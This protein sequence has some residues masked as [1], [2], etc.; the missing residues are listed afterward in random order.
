MTSQAIECWSAK[1][2]AAR[3]E[4]PFGQPRVDG[5]LDAGVDVLTLD[6]KARSEITKLLVPEFARNADLMLYRPQTGRPALGRRA[7]I[8]GAVI[9]NGPS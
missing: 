6:A 3:Q 7:S 4:V 2:N 5:Q 8:V 1:L 9:Q